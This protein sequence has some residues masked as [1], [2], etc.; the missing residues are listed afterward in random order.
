MA[1]RLWRAAFAFASLVLT[2]TT[3]GAQDQATFLIRLGND[4]VSAERVVLTAGKLEIDQATRFPRAMRRQGVVTMG[5]DGAV[6]A[7]EATIMRAGA[8]AGS[9]PVQR[10]AATFTRDSVHLEVHVDTMTRKVAAAVPAGAGIPVVSPWAMYDM[11]S[12][13]LAKSRNDSLHIPMYYLGSQ[14]LSW[15]AVRKLGRDS[16]EIQTEFDRYHARVDRNGRLLG[17][18]PLGGTQ[19]FSVERV[20][21]LDVAAYA[22]DFAARET[23]AGAMGQLS[24]RDTATAEV[25][26]AHLWVDYGRP[27]R[28][29]RTI[30]GGVVH[31][32]EVWRTGANAATQFRTDKPVS[33][34][35]VVVPV[36]MYTLWTIPTEQGWTLLVNSETGQWGTEHNPEKDVYRI[37]M[38]VARVDSPVERFTIHIAPGDKGGQIHFVWDQTVAAVDFT[39]SE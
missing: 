1:A 11:L 5:A 39:V 24:P 14:D 36:G 26:G 34:G 2:T 8:P 22:A 35:N 32:G 37:P 7:A 12:V 28:R 6:T 16:V 21:S 13:R 19:Q 4:T 3:A 30:F 38:S 27:S 10:S 23:Q 20:A 33:F 15:V 17:V 9:P 31:W 18:R 29:G 25:A